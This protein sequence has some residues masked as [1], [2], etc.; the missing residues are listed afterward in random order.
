[1]DEI[2][3]LGGIA[4]EVE[5]DVTVVVVVTVHLG[6]D[7]PICEGWLRRWERSWLVYDVESRVL[8]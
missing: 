7:V 4:I 6:D 5:V 1:M 2:V 3:G 8:L